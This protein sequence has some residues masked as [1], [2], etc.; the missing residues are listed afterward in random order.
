V[1][2]A[3]SGGVAAAVRFYGVVDSGLE[4]A[5]ELYLRREDAERVVRDW[6]REA[7]EQAGLLQVEVIEL[8]T[9]AN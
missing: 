9:S 6:D 1:G 4:E 8:E 3:G 2:A 7:P 5:V